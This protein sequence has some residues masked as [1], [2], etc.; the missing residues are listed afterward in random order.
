ML[1]GSGWGGW[2]GAEGVATVDGADAP[3]ASVWRLDAADVVRSLTLR[4]P[5][6]DPVAD[7]D[8]T[9][10]WLAEAQALLDGGLGLVGQ[11]GH[12]LGLALEG[13]PLPQP[14]SWPDAELLAFDP[15]RLLPATLP[16][17]P[18]GAPLAPP[19]PWQRE[20]AGFLADVEAVLGAVAA[21]EV[22]QANVTRPLTLPATAARGLRSILR[23][24]PDVALAA[25]LAAQPVPF[26][27]AMSTSAGAI[28]S[29]SMEL[30]LA[31]D[32]VELRS[33]PIKGTAPRV[34]PLGGPADVA[35]GAGLRASPKE[36]AE[37]VMITD[38]MR[39]DLGRVA[40]PDGVSAPALLALTGYRTLW[41]L[42]S[43][44]RAVL[45]A[46]ARLAD[47]L[48][49]TL[50]PASVAGAPKVAAMRLYSA[51][52]GR[53]R[54][55]YCGAFGLLLPER[56]ARLAVGIRLALLPAR[57]PL[58]VPVGAGIVADSDPAR[59]WAELLVKARATLAWLG[60]LT[61][62]QDG[63]GATAGGAA[64]AAAG[65]A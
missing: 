6:R 34:A 56:R 5:G 64:P 53:R 37:N 23:E 13:L 63:A 33:R 35:A 18:V 12:E 43:E 1:A 3:A 46:D 28:V 44:V 58:E 19:G 65:V 26:A 11:L 2:N 42:E 38:M 9:L 36:R 24:H 10:R 32:G 62:C 8:A 21:G 61:A 17:P 54:G 30:F 15:R 40:R 7:R 48:A 25:L 45:R 16:A 29:G 51:L 49:A 59:E 27:A 4:L 20:R 50:T 47:V 22:Y 39:N 52:E 55:P 41:H 14:G 31:C 57:G 60:R